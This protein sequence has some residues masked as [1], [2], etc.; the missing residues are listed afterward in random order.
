MNFCTN[1]GSKFSGEARFCAT[2]GSP[3][4]VGV[5]QSSPLLEY[6]ATSTPFVG[7]SSTS[8]FGQPFV[9]SR[10]SS[11]STL[12]TVLSIIQLASV[13][14]YLVYLSFLRFNLDFIRFFQLPHIVSM[15]ACVIPVIVNG[16]VPKFR[17]DRRAMM[18]S[19]FAGA[20]VGYQGFVALFNTSGFTGPTQ[21]P[22]GIWRWQEPTRL[23]TNGELIFLGGGFEKALYYLSRVGATTGLVLAVLLVVTIKPTTRDL[24]PESER[25]RGALGFIAVLFLFLENPGEVLYQEWPALSLLFF[26]LVLLAF[27]LQEDLRQGA[28]FGM[29][30]VIG[31]S[32]VSQAVVWL[33]GPDWF[34]Y[35]ELNFTSIPRVLALLACVGALI[36]KSLFTGP[37]GARPLTS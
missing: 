22:D 3:R 11:T 5:T 24:A 35:G 31:G 36:P 8:N 37:S 27:T 21:G 17:Q 7:G 18:A 12:V 33:I 6:G 32:I 30:C 25:W 2:C 29:V 34:W 26:A 4:Q 16:L 13:L 23:Q 1:C 10:P 14:V 20:I 19:A 9:P 28:A 15:V